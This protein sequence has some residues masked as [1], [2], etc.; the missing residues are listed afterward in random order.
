RAALLDQQEPV[1]AYSFDTA[2]GGGIRD[3][4]GHGF[5]ARATGALDLAP[6]VVGRAP[7]FEGSGYLAV[8]DDQ[9]LQFPRLTIAAWV[10][11][12]Q[13]AGRWGV[14]AKRTRNAAAP[15]VL[16]LRNGSVTFEAT[17]V[18]GA[19]SY[20]VT[21]PPV[22]PEGEWAHVAATCEEGVAVKLYCNGRLVAE[23]PVTELLCETSDVL[24]IG[25]EAWGG[26]D[27]Q[28]E[29][30]G[31]F[32]GLIDEIKL[33]SRV[34]SPEELAGEHAALRDAAQAAS[35]RLAEEAAARAERARLFATTTVADGGQG[36]K[37]AFFDDFERAELGADWKTLRG[38]WSI[39]DGVLVCDEVSFLGHGKPLRSPVRIEFDARSAHPGDLTAF[40]GTRAEAYVGGYFIGFA[41]NG[42]TANKILRLGQ[43]VAVNTG[44]LARP[45]EWHHV[46]GQVFD[47]RVQLIV[48]GELA[49]EYED[50]EPVTTADTAGLIAWGEGEFDN[51]R[52]YTGD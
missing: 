25:F 28:P 14:A 41:S 52:L 27:S 38:R 29:S 31:N 15:Y 35:Q 9:L 19:W 40:W 42:N 6:G 23:K 7:R 44:P 32:H 8:A 17:D 36:W 26:A 16:A 50:E 4:S 11:P 2:E 21:S 45:N 5:W 13:L 37:L 51:L 47:G 30:S 39:R 34:L 18:K 24:T 22:V 46:I 12:D 43:Q 10:L 33:W 20:N 1:A 48:D 49:L 3:D